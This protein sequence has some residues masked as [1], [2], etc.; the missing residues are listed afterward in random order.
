MKYI[1][2]AVLCYLVITSG[3]ADVID[4]N[5]PKTI[6]SDKIEYDVKSASIKTTGKTEITNTN[7]QHLT[8]TDITFTKDNNKFSGQDIQLW[9]GNRIYIESNSIEHDGDLTIAKDALF[10]ACD[11]CDSYGNAWEIWANKV[12][13]NSELK[14][15]YFYNPVL[16]M[17]NLPVFWMPYW[18]M[19]DP[20]VKYK[21]GLLMPDLS[22]TNKMGTL[23]NIPVYIS[24]SEYHDATVT[25]GYLTQENPLFQLEHRL[26]ATHSEFRTTSSFT[27]NKEGK[28]RWHIFNNDVIEFGEYVRSSIFLERASDKTY[29]QKYGFYDAQP[30]LDSGARIEVFGQSS[31]IV[32]DVHLFQELRNA[33]GNQSAPDGDILPNIR[34]QYQTAPIYKE[35]YAKFG[36]DI[37][38][39]SGDSSSVQR[40]IGDARIVS[41]WTLWGG[42]RITASLDARYDIYNFYNTELVDGQIYSGLKNR[43][44]PSGYLE[45]GL[46]LFKPS[47]TWTHILEPRARLTV[48]RRIDAEEF[49][50]NNDSAGAILTDTTLFSDNRFPGYDL[51]ENGTFADYGMRWSGFNSDGRSFEVFAGQSYDFTPLVNTDKNSGF[52][53][54]LSDYVGR[55]GFNNSSWLNLSSRFRFSQS[56]FELRHIETDARLGTSNNYLN[57]GH[58]WSKQLMDTGALDKG[59]H[60]AIAG[61]GIQIT[62]RLSTRFNAIYNISHKHFQRHSGG[63]FY[64][65]PCYYL[66]LEYHRDGAVNLVTDYVGNTTY[67]FKF[68]LQY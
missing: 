34:G 19:F 41:P 67:Q 46:P 18:E 28:N 23:I 15:L 25:F 2:F 40:L 5:S 26:N 13:H 32:G 8:L 51:W 58:M 37:L 45:W 7:G 11:G 65:H 60:E 24:L 62:N 42:N 35:T 36:T 27:H 20:T 47:D 33:S 68:G 61:L 29:L 9:L 54:G 59:I 56:D 21:S 52:H 39:I 63:L 53:D 66:S 64:N 55:V 31:Y 17:Y 43:F 22:S 14:K 50:L 10:T 48:M 16:Y 57:I 6:V 49:A 1:K 30:Y 44:L 12:K 4:M 38:G 3:Y